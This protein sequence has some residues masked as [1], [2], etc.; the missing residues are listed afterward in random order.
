MREPWIDFGVVPE[1]LVPVIQLVQR[2]SGPAGTST[3][4]GRDN[5]APPGASLLPIN[6]PT[7]R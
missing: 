3:P 1:D 2:G 4:W 5:Q 6:A 7:L